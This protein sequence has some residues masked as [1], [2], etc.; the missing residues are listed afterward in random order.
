VGAALLSRLQAKGII[1][2]RGKEGMSTFTKSGSERI[3]TFAKSVFDVTGAG[4]TVIAA[5]TLALTAGQTLE[6]ACLLANY[7]AG[8]V[9]GKIGCVST[10]PQELK[11]YIRSHTQTQG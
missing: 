6:E 2:T 1:V 7:A 5:L 11:E 10:S 9:V 3:P 4:D 8:V